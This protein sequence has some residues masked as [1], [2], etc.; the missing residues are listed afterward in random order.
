MIRWVAFLVGLVVAL[1]WWE[2]GR[3]LLGLILVALVL[4]L[5]QSLAIRV[6]ASRNPD[7]GMDGERKANEVKSEPNPEPLNTMSPSSAKVDE[8]RSRLKL[9]KR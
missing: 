2:V 7:V 1:A 6:D 4:D 3:W 5:L 8:V 9:G